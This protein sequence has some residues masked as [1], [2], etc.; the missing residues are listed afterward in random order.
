LCPAL[1]QPDDGLESS[2]LG[3]L[4]N[5]HLKNHGRAGLESSLLGPPNAGRA[6]HLNGVFGHLNGGL[7]PNDGL[8]QNA[9]RSGLLSFLGPLFSSLSYFS[10]TWLM[11]DFW[12]GALI[13]ARVCGVLFGCLP[14]GRDALA[15]LGPLE[16]SLG[17]KPGLDPAELNL[18][19][20]FQ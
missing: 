1:A 2:L 12:P 11:K 20:G 4:W 14:N 6:S 13:A 5:G 7:L 16:S 9:G 19:N 10:R 17:Q 15:S 3:H 8:A 18:T